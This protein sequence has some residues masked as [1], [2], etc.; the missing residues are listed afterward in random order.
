MT[1]DKIV[2]LMYHRVGVANNRWEQKY[3][4]SPERFA[5]HMAALASRGM[6]AVDV[7]QFVAW[8]EGERDLPH[9]SFLITFDD[10]FRGVREHALPTLEKYRWPATVFLVSDLIGKQDEWTRPFNPDGA[11]HTLL[12]A[13]EIRDMMRRGVSFHSHTCTH[14]SLTELDDIGLAEELQRSRAALRR[15]FGVD[16]EFLAYPF[17]HLNERVEEAARAAGYRAAFA[18]Q[19]GFNRRTA[20]R[21]RIRRLEVFGSDTPA[22]LVRKMKFGTNNGT[23]GEAARYYLRRLTTRLSATRS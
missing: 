2:A 10:G 15:L 8:M 23:M 3:C 16:C 5:M 9:G 18:T 6:N 4:V 14:P 20:D 12:D 11:T 7:L 1:A 22:M 17:G 13:E 19:P 21:Y